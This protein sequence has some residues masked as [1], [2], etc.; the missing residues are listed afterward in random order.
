ME[1]KKKKLLVLL[2]G[3]DMVFVMFISTARLN[4]NKEVHVCS[5]IIYEDK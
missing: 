4:S 1:I 5:L 2:F 3:I